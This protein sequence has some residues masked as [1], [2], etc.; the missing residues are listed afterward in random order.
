MRMRGLSNVGRAVLM[1]LTLLHYASA[2]TEQIK[3]WELLAHKFDRFKLCATT[4]N[5]T[6]QHAYAS[7]RVH[8]YPLKTLSNLFY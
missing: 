8:R 7:N 6:Q 2:I 5:N 3:C 1:D 4:P